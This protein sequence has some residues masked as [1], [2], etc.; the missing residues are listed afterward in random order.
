MYPKGI[1]E[2]L[3]TGSLKLY[4]GF[5]SSYGGNFR[6]GGYPVYTGCRDITDYTDQRPEAVCVSTNGG[7]ITSRDCSVYTTNQCGCLVI[8]G[9]RDPE[10]PKFM[11]HASPNDWMGYKFRGR[12]YANLN[13]EGRTENIKQSVQRITEPLRRKYGS[14]AGIQLVMSITLSNE[15]PG[16]N[17]SRTC[18]EMD[19][20]RMQSAF[21]DLG[22]QAGIVEIPVNVAS[23]LSSGEKPGEILII[24]RKAWIDPQDGFTRSSQ[25]VSAFRVDVARASAQEFFM[26]SGKIE[27]AS[28]LPTAAGRGFPKYTTLDLN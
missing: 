13:E 3:Q 28:P 8:S 11:V 4:E 24:G 26:P 12:D 22:I 1:S 20:R 5:L 2:G 27:V 10:E 9:M 15:R 21:A 14:V 17:Y 7:A 6:A 16:E 19:C 18:Q 23:T 25:D